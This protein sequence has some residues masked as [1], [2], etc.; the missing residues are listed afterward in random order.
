MMET[1]GNK[2]NCDIQKIYEMKLKLKF[3]HLK[4]HWNSHV[5]GRSRFGNRIYGWTAKQARRQDDSGG[6]DGREG[7]G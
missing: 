3:S 6:G 1:F 2:F 5:E 4:L 7:R